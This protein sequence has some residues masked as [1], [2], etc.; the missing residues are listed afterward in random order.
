MQLVALLCWY[1]ENPDWLYDTVRSLQL[2]EADHLIAVDGGIDLFPEAA[3]MSAAE[4]YAALY[5]AAL[6][7]GI[8][9]TTVTPPTTWATEMQKR[10]AAFERAER[11]TTEDDWYFV[12]DGDEVVERASDV[13]AALEA[14]DFDA[15]DIS[16][17][18]GPATNILRAWVEGED[19]MDTYTDG[20][21]VC[22]TR[23]L[24]RAIR[25]LRVTYNHFTYELP[26]GRQM[27]GH[28][29]IPGLPFHN[30]LQLDHRGYLRDPE[31]AEEARVYYDL[32]N[33]AGV[34]KRI[35]RIARA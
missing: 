6:E 28:D 35:T 25:G 10:S 24:Y 15:A 1:R 3:P 5:D 21:K 8:G 23:R 27:W 26:D 30:G 16:Y 13:K 19:G 11:I 29:P 32:R 18:D 31:R 4:E 33:V 12:I 2:V 14:T 17:L 7:V 20:R 34:E 22:R 9:L